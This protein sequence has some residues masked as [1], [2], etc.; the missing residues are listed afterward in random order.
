MPVWQVSNSIASPH[1]CAS[2]L[3]YVPYCLAIILPLSYC[4]LHQVFSILIL[5]TNE[6]VVK[7]NLSKYIIAFDATAG[8]ASTGGHTK[9]T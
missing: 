8:Y 3:V 2:I 5:I 9:K 7:L 1:F 4:M 6:T